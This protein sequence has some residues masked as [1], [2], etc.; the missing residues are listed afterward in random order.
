MYIYLKLKLTRIDKLTKSPEIQ[1]VHLEGI[2]SM[3][4]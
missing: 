3:V 4:M 1:N 2:L